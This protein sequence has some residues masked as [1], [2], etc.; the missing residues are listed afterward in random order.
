[1]MGDM[2][3]NQ[4]AGTEKPWQVIDT[5]TGKALQVRYET[6]GKA[7]KKAEMLNRVYGAVRFTPRLLPTEA[8]RGVRG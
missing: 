4:T 6:Y 2:E 8:W 3:N 1:M 7:N 5:Q